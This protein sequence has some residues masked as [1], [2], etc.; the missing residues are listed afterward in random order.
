MAFILPSESID[1]S[2]SS[3]GL[4]MNGQDS[5]VQPLLTD[6]YQIT[7]C[8]SYWK[9]GTHN[10]TAVF[11][12]FFRKNPFH[13]EFTVFAGL[14][15]C[16]RFVENFK[17]SQSDIEYLKKIL[18]PNAEP[19][20]FEYLETLDGSRLTIKAV[21]EGSVVFPKVPLLT[22]EGPLAMC[23]LLET[24]ILNL[25]NYA[26]LVATNAARFRQASGWKIQLLE[27]GL[28]RAQGPNGGLT[29]SK[30]CYIGG[31]DGTS[32]VLAGKLYGIPVKGTQAHSFICS[33][34]TPDELQIRNLNHKKTG[35]AADLFDLSLK[36]RAWILEQFPWGVISS[37]VS[38]GELA[39]FVAYA[40][41]FPDTF[42]ALIDT[43]DVLRSGVVNFVA[44]SLALHD[45]GY[46]SMGVRIDSGDLSYLSK[47]LRSIFVKVAA[48]KDEYKFFEKMPIVA[49]NDINEET[50]MSLNEQQHEI[51]AFGVGTHLVTCQKQPALGCVYKLV[52]KSSQ[53]KIKLSQ[54]VTKITIPG[55]KKCYRIYGRNGYAILDLMMLEDEPEP[56]LNEQILCRHPFEES[57]RA[58]VNASKIERLHNVYWEN[59]KLTGPLPTLNETKEHVND[60]IR[61]TLRQD[62]RRYLNPTPYK[63]S[64]SER[65]YN[66]LHEL[67]LQN[68]PIG[69][70]ERTDF[71]FWIR[72][73]TSL[74][75]DRRTTTTS[76]MMNSFGKMRKIKS[77][78]G[79]KLQIPR[80]EV[81]RSSS[82]H[83]PTSLTLQPIDDTKLSEVSAL[84]SSS[85]FFSVV[86]APPSQASFSHTMVRYRCCFGTC[87]LRV[88]ACVIGI[89]CIL[90][91]ILSLCSL[92]TVSTSM[93]SDAQSFLTTPIVLSLLQF[94]TSMIMIVAVL[95]SF[96]YL[97]IPFMLTCSA[98]LLALIVLCSWAVVRRHD[99]SN[100]VVP[101]LLIGSTGASLLYLWFLTIV[102]MT[103]VLIRDR[104]IMGYDDE[105][106]IENRQFDRASSSI[107]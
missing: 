69:Q 49:S 82:L 44:V 36:T 20:F 77:S 29:A 79:N 16:L 64:V 59:G 21:R 15:D 91:S 22:L 98:N 61:R 74:F 68:A 19:S 85:S 100:A 87:R 28:R 31:F 65:L 6:F 60:S 80:I 11:D 9:A 92:L 41:S 45:L 83:N 55:K 10:E 2:P 7:M 34:S 54:D 25:V 81:R 50:I 3:N 86:S 18:P 1:G 94:A 32:N 8:Y 52:A 96:H 38:N 57:K 51:N 101:L 103:F 73:D 72:V 33:F 99:L 95:T 104:K 105:F 88:G 93:T 106:D 66:F 67:W 97:L 43:Y 90:I 42:L 39:A 26:S 58:L 5:L 30:Y 40:I 71:Y 47:E 63:V 75:S 48:L 46:R 84:T 23:Q 70:L 27:F 78:C 12:V 13:G 53:P 17:F 62:H 14:E 102:S 24:S 107:V 4:H 89:A 56:K 37:E 35:E 76:A